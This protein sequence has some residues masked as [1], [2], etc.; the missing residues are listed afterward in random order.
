MSRALRLSPCLLDGSIAYLVAG[1]ADELAFLVEALP[2]G[3]DH[4]LHRSVRG[5]TTSCHVW[6]AW[7]STTAGDVHDLVEEAILRSGVDAIV[8]PI[9]GSLVPAVP[10]GCGA[11]CAVD[12]TCAMCLDAPAV[13]TVK[14]VPACADCA[15]ACRELASAD[16]LPP[17]ADSE[18]MT[19][20][21]GIL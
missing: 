19:F 6:P 17:D 20:C 21:A 13:E 12:G 4:D 7:A 1:P 16:T 9:T 14:N 10:C 11:H 8:S 3:L 2:P 5:E 15:A 18:L